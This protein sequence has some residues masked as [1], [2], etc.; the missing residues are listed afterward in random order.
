MTYINKLLIVV[1]SLNNII[2]IEPIKEMKL[3]V[4]DKLEIKVKNL[5]CDSKLLYTLIVIITT[6]IA[7]KR[8]IYN[9]FIMF[10][11]KLILVF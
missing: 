6:A 1:L 9:G 11:F 7:K 4:I 5:N 2:K 8:Y 3:K 10:I